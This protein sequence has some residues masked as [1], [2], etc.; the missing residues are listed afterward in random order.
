MDVPRA[1]SLRYEL[2]F[3]TSDVA[4]GPVVSATGHVANIVA[5]C[6][7]SP[8]SAYALPRQTPDEAL[9]NAPARS[10]DFFAVPAVL[11]PADDQSH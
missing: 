1:G 4:Q 6:T 5:T 9:R 3:P 2:G 11:D 8:C 10:G 7:G